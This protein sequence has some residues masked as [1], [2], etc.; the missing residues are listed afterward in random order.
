MRII[1][2]LLITLVT[3]L[4]GWH[5][6]Q[7][8][9]DVPDQPVTTP[10]ATML[11]APAQPRVASVPQIVALP[12]PVVIEPLKPLPPPPPFRLEPLAVRLAAKGMRKGDDVFFRI[13]KEESEAELWLSRDGQPFRHFQTYPICTWSGA[14]GPKLKEG[15]GQ[16]PEGFYRVNRK[17]LKPNSDY[18]RAF[19]LGFPNAY[20]RAQGRTGSFLMV[21]G[22]CLSV[23]CYAMTDG[24]I[25]EI[26]GF[27][28]A[29]L[30]RSGAEFDVHVLPFRPT[31]ANLARHAQSPWAG[32]WAN[33]K[34]GHDFFERTRRP[35]RVAVQSGRYV[36][37]NTAMAAGAIR[38]AGW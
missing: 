16:S 33:L 11:P 17:Q 4:T 5:F 13:F 34:E 18:H 23:G 32:F 37:G 12:P 6:S 15:D 22:N 28:D 19:N 27:V 36:F 2:L 1:A 8:R 38:I 20:D 14:L 35:P 29:G 26:Y 24:L 30:G 9:A 10:P 21:H 3:G 7:R 31:A 25:E